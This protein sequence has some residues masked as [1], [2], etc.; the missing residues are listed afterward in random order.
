MT[1]FVCK[2]VKRTSSEPLPET[3][4]PWLIP[5]VR[6]VSRLSSGI[7]SWLNG[8]KIPHSDVQ[9]AEGVGAA[10]LVSGFLEL[11]SGIPAA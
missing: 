8:N 4:R 2:K 1:G 10:W 7:R 11:I 9:Y 5:W 6:E 3:A